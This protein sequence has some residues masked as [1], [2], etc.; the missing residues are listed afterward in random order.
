MDRTPGASRRIRGLAL[1]SDDSRSG[2]LD[3]V[4][5]AGARADALE[6]IAGLNYSRGR[7]TR[8]TAL[9]SRPARELSRTPYRESPESWDGA[10][11]I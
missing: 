4:A 6:E 3:A 2:F 9:S 8:I 1:V 10:S 11:A 5:K 7:N